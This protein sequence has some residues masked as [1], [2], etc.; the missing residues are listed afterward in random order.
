MGSIREGGS[1][2]NKQLPNLIFS[3]ENS[4]EIKIE[5]WERSQH[6]GADATHAILLVLISARFCTQEGIF[7]LL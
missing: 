5:R 3:K 1:K 6:K 4:P 7:Y 2:E